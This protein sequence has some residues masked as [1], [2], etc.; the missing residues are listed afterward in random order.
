[1]KL[2]FYASFVQLGPS[3]NLKLKSWSDWTK[4]NTKLTFKPPPPPTT[5][6]E[7]FLTSSRQPRRVK[8]KMEAHFNQTK[9]NLKK[10]IEVTWPPTPNQIGLKYVIWVLRLL[11][12]WN[13]TSK[14]NSTKLKEICRFKTLS[15]NLAFTLKAN[16]K[17]NTIAYRLVTHYLSSAKP[18]FR[19]SIDLVRPSIV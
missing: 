8:F 6:T 2:N 18:Q 16:P 12:G 3:P 5:T 15:P 1:M 17:L 11:E 19:P 7:N 10:K 14:L 13:L 4:A 9:R